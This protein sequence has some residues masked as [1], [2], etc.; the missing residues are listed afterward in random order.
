[1][2][3]QL[4]SMLTPFPLERLRAAADEFEHLPLDAPKEAVEV[5][6]DEVRALL[7][8]VMM[9]SLDAYPYKLSWN[10][11]TQFG[12]PELA[13]L[14]AMPADTPGYED[15]LFHLKHLIKAAIDYL[16]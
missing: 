4:P 14:L 12:D 3:S 6:F 1:M 11:L 13:A 10:T 7:L 2:T 9:A 8:D 5:R 16:P 15:A